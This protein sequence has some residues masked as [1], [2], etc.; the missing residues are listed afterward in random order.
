MNPTRPSRRVA[1]ITGASSGIGAAAAAQLMT[2]GYTVY[3]TSR[4]AQSAPHHA[5]AMLIM[6]VTDDQSVQHAVAELISREGRI[7]LLV[8]N[9]G[10]GMTGAAE[11]STI[12]Q[13]QT[14]FD[15]NFHGVVRVTHAVLPHMRRQRE[16]RILNL[17]SVLGFIPAPFS[18][19]YGATKHALAG[20]SEALD[21][22]VRG[23]GIRV[24]VIEPGATKTA[25]E[26]STTSAD[27]A[28]TAY[29][30]LRAGYRVA[31]ARTMAAADTPESVAETIVQAALAKRPLLRYPSGKAA[32]QLAWVRRFLPRALFDK[33]LHQQFGL[34]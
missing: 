29:D 12:E 25:F 27:Q 32:K 19:Y 20:Y 23:F 28:L 17:G 11:E 30:G 5:H 13:V 6:D 3:G 22:E 24:A 10:V 2:A 34:R 33:A 26:S 4:R 8:N 14:L 18:A 31:F 9:A 15:T 21:H 7:D 1:L 16:G